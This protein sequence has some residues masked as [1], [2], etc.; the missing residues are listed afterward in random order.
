MTIIVG[1]NQADTITGTGKGDIILSGN[2]ADLV[3]GGAGNT[4][5]GNR[6]NDVAVYVAAESSGN[7]EPVV[8]GFLITH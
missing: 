7:T 4:V 6:G 1:T 3:D 5:Y 2:G 8:S